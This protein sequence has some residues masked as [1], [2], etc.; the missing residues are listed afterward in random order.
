M[1][2]MSSQAA[3]TS[4]MPISGLR[5]A[6]MLIIVS[7]R[8]FVLQWRK[9]SQANPNWREGLQAGKLPPWGITAFE[10][11]LH[12]FPAATRRPLDVCDLHCPWLSSDE[13]RFLW[14]MSLFQHSLNVEAESMLEEWLP[15]TAFRLAS[16]PAA[17]LASAL[18]RA[19]LIIPLRGAAASISEYRFSPNPNQIRGH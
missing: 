11:L 3:H 18:Q 17:S 8:L 7:L 4:G 14:I 6:E 5:T 15:P 13:G 16:Y 12:I 10:R 2:M 9:P 1:T 19:N